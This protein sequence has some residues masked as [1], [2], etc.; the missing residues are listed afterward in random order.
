MHSEGGKHILTFLRG[1]AHSGQCKR[2]REVDGIDI[3]I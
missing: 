3:K 1:K 2:R